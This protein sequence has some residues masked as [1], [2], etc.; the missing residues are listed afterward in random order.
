MQNEFESSHN[1][2]YT[3]KHHGLSEYGMNAQSTFSK[4][5]QGNL[6]D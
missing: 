2:S 4:E 1:L 3:L 5:P 6:I